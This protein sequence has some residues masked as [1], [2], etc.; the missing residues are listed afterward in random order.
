MFLVQLEFLVQPEEKVEKKNDSKLFLWEQ[1][2]M[3]L[4]RMSMF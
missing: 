1:D 2:G 3:S 4:K